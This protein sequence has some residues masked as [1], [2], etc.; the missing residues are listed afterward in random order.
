MYV[1]C[2][3]TYTRV[4]FTRCVDVVNNKSAYV[5]VGSDVCAVRCRTVVLRKRFHRDD[6]RNGSEEGLSK[7]PWQEAAQE[8]LT[9]PHESVCRR[10][11]ETRRKLLGL[12]EF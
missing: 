11:L 7:R 8:F 1:T 2:V 9:G 5:I 4:I 10:R 12:Q 6:D 3:R